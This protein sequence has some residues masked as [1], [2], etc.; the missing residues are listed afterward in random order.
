MFFYYKLF[1][2]K[3][4]GFCAFSER[5]NCKKQVQSARILRVKKQ[6]TILIMTYT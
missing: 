3:Q 5:I 4:A 2:C 6:I 1:I